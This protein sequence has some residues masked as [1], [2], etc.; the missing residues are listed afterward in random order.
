MVNSLKASYD[1]IFKKITVMLNLVG[2]NIFKK[3]F[4]IRQTIFVTVDILIFAVILC[5]SVW[6]FRNDYLRVAICVVPSFYGVQ[7][8]IVTVYIYIYIYY[9]SN[10]YIF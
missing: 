8:S 9:T 10:I 7:V 5:Y 2:L 1:E 6:Y 4:N 3:S